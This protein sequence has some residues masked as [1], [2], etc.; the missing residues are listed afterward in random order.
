MVATNL[1]IGCGL[2]WGGAYEQDLP[3]FT[4]EDDPAS[5]PGHILHYDL[6]VSGFVAAQFGH[7]N[8]LGLSDIEFS[9]TPFETPATGLPIV[10]WA[11]AQGPRVLVGMN[12]GQRWPGDGSFP[13]LGGCCRPFEFPVHVANGTISFL[14]EE[15]PGAGLPISRGTMRLWRAVQNCGFRVALTG[16]SDFPCIWSQV[17]EVRTY[18]LIEGELSYEAFLEGIRAGRT[19]V[20][21]GGADWMDLAV[22]DVRQGGD[23]ETASGDEV[24]V[25]I[26]SNL[27][28]RDRVTLQVNGEPVETVVVDA[29]DQALAMTLTLE[30]SSWIAA[31][32]SRVQT[33]AIYVL[34]DEKPIRASAD[35]ACYLVRYMDYLSSLVFTGRFQ[36]DTTEALRAYQSARDVFQERFR[37][38]GGTICVNVPVAR[39][40]VSPPMDDSPVTVC[41]D[42]SGSTTPEGQPLGA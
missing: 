29:G 38:A 7:L 3:L 9:D 27:S 34:V 30:K 13:V 8:I 28:R 36:G 42:A 31:R 32:S 39:F 23:V 12:H 11:L 16:A 5:M 24:Q 41:V 37:E 25:E 6:E 10:E 1:N 33:S 17:G 4:G 22:N 18:V 26:E 15:N 35:D 2:V 14:E 20:A 40:T 21:V 19:S